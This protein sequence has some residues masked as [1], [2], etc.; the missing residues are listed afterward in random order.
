[1]DYILP[2]SIIEGLNERFNYYNQMLKGWSIEQIHAFTGYF[3]NDNFNYRR[4]VSSNA[5]KKF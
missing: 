3:Y 4:R 2:L 5:N 1:M